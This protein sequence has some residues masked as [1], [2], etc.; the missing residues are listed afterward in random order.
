MV[1]RVVSPSQRPK[2]TSSDF[3]P[4]ENRTP[5]FILVSLATQ[6]WQSLCEQWTRFHRRSCN[7]WTAWCLAFIWITLFASIYDPYYSY[8]NESPFFEINPNEQTWRFIWALRAVCN[9]FPFLLIVGCK[10]PSWLW[11]LVVPRTLWTR[12]K[13]TKVDCADIECCD[14]HGILIYSRSPFSQ[15]LLKRL[16]PRFTSCS[17]R[18]GLSTHLLP[19]TDI[20]SNVI[21]LGEESNLPSIIEHLG[22][23]L[24]L[25]NKVTHFCMGLR[26]K[27]WI[28]WNW[29][30]N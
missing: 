4:P 15:F 6:L 3:I 13:P 28:E 24:I 26:E 14:F 17:K 2:I 30:R 18:N 23:S 25:P 11:T 22:A 10:V 19:K 5:K 12:D 20:F 16:S 1:K 7:N 27:K 21:L 8:A 9:F 29:Q